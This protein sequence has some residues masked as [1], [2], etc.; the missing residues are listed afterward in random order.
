MARIGMFGAGYVGLVTGAC[1]ADLGHEVVIRDILPDRIELQRRAEQSPGAHRSD[2]DAPA[3]SRAQR[4]D[5]DDVLARP[6]SLE[7]PV[8]RARP[9]RGGA[10]LAGLVAGRR[11][12]VQAR[13]SPPR[14]RNDVRDRLRQRLLAGH[15][16]RLERRSGS[17]PRDGAGTHRRPDL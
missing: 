2:A 4:P 15:R 14:A 9:D 10:Q 16:D 12:R 11:A 17:S 1:F 6:G 8:P 13:G 5:V 7:A 3:A